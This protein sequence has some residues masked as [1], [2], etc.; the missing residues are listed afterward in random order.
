MAISQPL[1]TDK[2]GNPDHSLMHRI[3]ASDPG[4]SVK[5]IAVDS[6]NKVQLSE[7]GASID[8]FSTDGTLAGNSDTAVPTEQAVKTYAD[9]GLA[10]V[11]V[12]ALTRDLA[13]ATGDVSTTGVG[14]TPKVIIAFGMIDVTPNACW[15]FSLQAVEGSIFREYEATANFGEC[16]S[17]QWLSTEAGARQ[18][19]VVK[20]FDADGFTL[21]WTK[22]GSPTGTAYIKILCIR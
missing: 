20:S 21:T 10:K 15:G 22:V 12:V 7:Q 8:E 4:A 9:S 17:L 19:A 2:L 14:F 5:S 3:I 1:S 18:V 16:N 13:A 6:T 11:K